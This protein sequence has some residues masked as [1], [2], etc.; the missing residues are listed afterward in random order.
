MI[1]Q[2]LL[3]EI[4]RQY[5]HSTDG[6]HGLAHWQR[7]HENGLFLAARTG[8]NIEVVELF[9]LLHDACRQNDGRDP[10]HGPRAAALARSLQGTLLHLAELDLALLTYACEY[11]TRGLTKADVTVETCWDADRLDLGRIGIR[12]EP[13]RLCTS[14][15][16][17]PAVIE[18]GWRRSQGR[19]AACPP[20]PGL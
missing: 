16:R 2:A 17:D 14:P 7:V 13:G 15:A 18:W 4:L 8:A 12:P 11:H 5:A 20:S 19:P 1:D 3:D 6:I 9:A 10:D